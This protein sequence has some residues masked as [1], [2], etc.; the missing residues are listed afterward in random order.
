MTEPV[1]VWSMDIDNKPS[2]KELM[3]YVRSISYEESL[4]K[5]SKLELILWN[6]TVLNN[7]ATKDIFSR[8][9]QIVVFAGWEKDKYI[10]AGIIDDLNLS[11]SNQTLRVTCYD[12]GRDLGRDINQGVY[13]NTKDSDIAKTLAGKYGLTPAIDETTGVVNRTQ[14]NKTDYRFLADLAVLNGFVFYVDFDV[15]K[16]KWY[17][18]FK[19]PVYLAQ[20]SCSLYDYTSHDS[21][22]DDFSPKVSG[23]IHKHN[24]LVLNAFIT[25][26][27][28]DVSLYEMCAGGGTSDTDIT[29][30]IL[31]NMN[32]QSIDEAKTF[33]KGQAD[34]RNQIYMTAEATVLGD[35]RTKIGDICKWKG[36]TF[37]FYGAVLDGE[38]RIVEFNHLLSPPDKFKTQFKMTRT[39]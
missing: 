34:I 14:H 9:R 13:K 19:K 28:K 20:N 23:E 25:N 39:K 1:L 8:G 38:Y 11:T 31:P 4:G 10:G 7:S 5:M 26:E 27:R 22:V 21:V 37:K 16:R 18:N 3:S 35:N 24:K 2:S 6:P 17:L 15:F 32:F 36:L 12:K 29:V 33:L 30:E